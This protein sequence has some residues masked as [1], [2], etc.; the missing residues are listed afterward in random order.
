MDTTVSGLFG[1]VILPACPCR[2]DRP[3]VETPSI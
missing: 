1:A 3:L 2:E